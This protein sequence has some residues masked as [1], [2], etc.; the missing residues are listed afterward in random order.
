[1]GEHRGAQLISGQGSGPLDPNLAFG[2]LYLYELQV[3]VTYMPQSYINK[4]ATK[5]WQDAGHKTSDSK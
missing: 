3:K 1:M 4:T 5:D 2:N